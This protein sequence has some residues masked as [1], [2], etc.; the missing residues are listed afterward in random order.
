MATLSVRLGR[1]I[2]EIC[3]AGGLAVFLWMFLSP[4]IPWANPSGSVLIFT[5]YTPP[6]GSAPPVSCAPTGLGGSS[7]SSNG[8]S[9]TIHHARLE[10]GAL[11][12]RNEISAL[13]EGDLQA[14]WVGLLGSCSRDEDGRTWCTKPSLS[15]PQFNLT[16]VQNG[17]VY[18][19][20]SYLQANLDTK[21]F[22]ILLVLDVVG[23]AGYLLVGLFHQ[24]PSLFAIIPIDLVTSVA[25][26]LW[27]Y[28]VI[29]L[30]V[31]F[32][33]NFVVGIRD[34]D[35]FSGVNAFYLLP[36]C[37]G[38]PQP[39]PGVLMQVAKLGGGRNMLWISWCI[40][41]LVCGVI[42]LGCRIGWLRDC[43]TIAAAKEAARKRAERPVEVWSL[44]QRL[45]WVAFDNHPSYTMNLL[46]RF[47]MLLPDM[48]YAGGL[49][50]FFWMF[51]TP[52]PWANTSGSALIFT[53]YTPPVGYVPPNPCALPR[54][55]SNFVNTT[56]TDATTTPR[57]PLRFARS[58]TQPISA[59]EIPAT[60]GDTGLRAIWIG[61]LGTCSRDDDGQIWCT[62]PSISEPKFNITGVQANSI[63][64]PESL[65]KKINT[66]TFFAFLILDLIGFVGYIFIG[67][68]HQLPSLFAFV[69][70]GTVTSIS[71]C[72]LTYMILNTIPRFWANFFINV[73]GVS[74][75]NDLSNFYQPAACG[76]IPQLKPGVLM[77]AASGYGENM[78]WTSWVMI[79]I[80]CLACL[81]IRHIWLADTKTIEEAKRAVEK[82]EA[83]R[84]ARD[85]QRTQKHQAQLDRK[86]STASTNS[87]VAETVV[88]FPEPQVY[89]FDLEK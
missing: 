20:T 82:A 7:S 63:F 5:P 87:S 78:L 48:C 52:V 89:K 30:M 80:V 55:G 12:P 39:E 75:F 36:A 24:F 4:S 77:R 66:K 14:V 62:K 41:Y 2:P 71:T 34:V 86:K 60:S 3:Y 9:S 18:D 67:L 84:K 47:V 23:F 19:P 81:G 29:N 13:K 73:G 64:Y 6:S 28:M 53:P 32:W 69:P 88:A 51:L 79:Y 61:L 50:V 16:V 72:L 37:E 70:I 35:S 54:I 42:F 46:L 56:E 21:W 15:K 27:A 31:R 33:A 26:M 10:P 83:H 59:E 85:D 38:M 1:L 44:E 25:T 11:I 40:I 65:E 57:T 76:E 49:V 22:F 58:Q 43:A 17:T 8:T 74:D 68:F 45:E